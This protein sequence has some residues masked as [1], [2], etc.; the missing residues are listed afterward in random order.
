MRVFVASWFFPPSTS[1]EGIVTYKL[2]R[3]SSLE[4]DVVCSSSNQWGYDQKISM[5]ADNVRRYPIDTDDLNEWREETIKLF[6]KLHSEHSYNV[7]MTRC[8]PNESMEIGLRIKEEFPSVKWICS[9]ADP[10]GN[11]PYWTFAISNIAEI[12]GREKKEILEDLQLPRSRWR[13]NWFEHPS[14][15]IRDNF[16]WK[17]IQDKSFEK[18]D[19][20]ITPSVEQRNFMDPEKKYWNKFIIVPH[21]YDDQLNSQAERKMDWDKDL[22]H[23]SYTGYSDT[24]RSLNPFIEAVHWI[25]DR[26]P[27]TLDK[28]RFHLFGNYPREIV[29]RVYAYGIDKVFDF[30]GN[31]SYLDT[32][33]VMQQSD[34]LLHVDAFCGGLPGGSRFFAGKLAD[35][36]GAGKP[37]L[38]LTGAESPAGAI[39]ELY[40]GKRIN[41]WETVDIAKEIIKISENQEN[42]EVNEGFRNLFSAGTVAKRFD[43]EVQK[44]LSKKAPV[45]ALQLYDQSSHQNKALTVCVP[46]YNAEQTLGRTLDSLLNIELRD[47]LEVIIV[48]DGSI[49]G[50]EDIARQYVERYP[51]S[52]ILVSK[53]NGGHGSGINQGI[54]RATGTYFRVVDS[55]DWVDS[56]ALNKELAYITEADQ[57]PDVIYTLYDIVLQD[58]GASNRWPLSEDI[59]YNRVYR[60]KELVHEIGVKDFYFTMAATSFKTELLKASNLKLKEKCF[61]TDSEFILKPIPRVQ[62]AVFLKAAVYKYLRGQSEQSVAPL[63]FV[64]HYNDHETVLKE[65]INFE[66]TTQMSE[67]HRKYL[68]YIIDQHLVTNY[69]I[70][71]EFDPDTERGIE[72]AKE[73]DS[74]LKENA[75][76]Y[77]TRAEK[78]SRLASLLH[79]CHYS[80]KTFAKY[81][82]LEERS[83]VSLKKR[84]KRKGKKI[85]HSKLFSNRYTMKFIRKQKETN[86][87]IYRAY[88]KM[89]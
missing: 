30:N 9:M 1:S 27:E 74:W 68:N 51:Q 63:S 88:M 11:N 5:D 86:G 67:E 46:S 22:I 40:G 24:L 7:I 87:F 33:A 54:E 4:Y 48:N 78:N 34:W 43:E 58:T 55:D 83:K 79:R 57:A 28:I 65:L 19:R 50:T 47:S 26:Y 76:D 62:T 49:D 23:F 81:R 12:S 32:L 42:V 17:D 36:M 16:Y 77:Y 80:E 69:R 41:A 66:K 8:M 35:Y 45:Q 37:V 59:E 18:A 44:L 53:P 60:F 71:L 85:L 29:D 3:H 39:I 52:V 25:S 6:R 14:N 64:R 20:I 56:K 73:F 15:T 21:S 89:K 38:G 13:R 84:I 10:V 82:K 61:Y 31:V 2:L 70:Q 75:P 72:R